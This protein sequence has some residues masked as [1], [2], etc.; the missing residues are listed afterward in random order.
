MI[1]GLLRVAARVL[2][3]IPPHSVVQAGVAYYFYTKLWQAI[4][5]MYGSRW[6]IFGTLAVYGLYQY[7]KSRKDERE[8]SVNTCIYTSI[9]SCDPVNIS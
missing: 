1:A 5:K 2:R 9:V 7:S 3:K 8:W 4:N 6:P